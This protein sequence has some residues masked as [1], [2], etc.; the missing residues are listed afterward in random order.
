V[1][2]LR[3]YLAS[4]SPRRRDLLRQIGIVPVVVSVSVDERVLSG[5]S[6]PDLVRRLA[7]AKARHA[8]GSLA[9]EAPGVVLAADTAVVIDRTCLGKPSDA[10]ESVSMLRRLRG[11]SHEVLTGVF[12][13][14]TDDPRSL[15]EVH[16]TRVQFRHFDDATLDAY[17]A[18]G[19]GR[20]KAGAYGIQGR[21]ALLAERIEGSWSNVV[22]LPLER[23]PEWTARLGIDFWELVDG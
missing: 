6:P 7:E 5:E 12:M 20:D 11:R 3:F 23:I 18:F 8:L 2:T 14:R 13:L 9:V 1:S 10:R 21:G 22:G 4:A 19:E 16:S 17:V 15:S